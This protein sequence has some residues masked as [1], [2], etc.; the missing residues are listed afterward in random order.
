MMKQ[1]ACIYTVGH[2]AIMATAKLMDNA[3]WGMDNSGILT[4]EETAKSI[5]IDFSFSGRSGALIGACLN[6][7]NLA[8]KPKF[9]ATING[10][11]DF[12]D[13][14][15]HLR[16]LSSG[17][18]DVTWVT[19]VP[20]LKQGTLHT[21]LGS[22]GTGCDMITIA[23][24]EWKGYVN[25]LDVNTRRIIFRNVLPTRYPKFFGV[26]ADDSE[27]CEVSLQIANYISDKFSLAYGLNDLLK[28]FPSSMEMNWGHG[29]TVVFGDFPMAYN[30]EDAFSYYREI[31]GYIIP[32]L[33]IN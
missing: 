20:H 5:L 10:S 29:R 30:S 28:R 21:W 15:I 23:D 26:V 14:Y 6:A 32:S 18:E 7:S 9:Y 33:N 17:R 2:D 24:N 25:C 22:C 19:E 16:R 11:N 31:V 4:I 27:N 1:Q 12:G 8:D 13:W 3:P